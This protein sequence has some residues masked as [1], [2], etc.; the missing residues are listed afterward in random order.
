M[1]YGPPMGRP[2]IGD[3]RKMITLPAEL[4]RAIEDYRFESRLKTEAEA[5]RQLIEAGLKAKP[6]R[7]P[8]G[9]PSP[10]SSPKPGADQ[11]AEPGASKPS[12]PRKAAPRAKPAAMPKGAQIRALR[13]PDTQ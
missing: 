9:R 2:R 8:S 12:S 6:D 1:C 4:T 10:A 7:Q 3:T 11:D 13:E 5:I